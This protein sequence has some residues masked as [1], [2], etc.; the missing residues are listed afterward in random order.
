MKFR[1]PKPWGHRA[2]GGAWGGSNPSP[3]ASD[4]VKR[5]LFGIKD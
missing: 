3:S 5:H 4:L 2:P 1:T